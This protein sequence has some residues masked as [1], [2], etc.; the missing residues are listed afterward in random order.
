[1]AKTIKFNLRIDGIAIRSLED[2]QENFVIDDLVEFYD[3]GLLQK[4]LSVRGY[5]EQARR[6]QSFKRT[7]DEKLVT[8]L[9][10]IFE[11]PMEKR[12]FEEELLSL[13]YKK[14]RLR[15]I[16]ENSRLMETRTAFI[17]KYH[18]EYERLLLSLKDNKDD[19]PSIKVTL[20]MIVKLYRR[21]FRVDAVRLFYELKEEAPLAIFAMLMNEE[22]RKDLESNVVID[23]E[24][25]KLY[26]EER[27]LAKLGQNLKI[28]KGAT[29]GYWKNLCDSGKKYMVVSM[30]PGNYVGSPGDIKKEYST[31]ETNGFYLILDGLIYKSNSP[32]QQ[33]RYMEV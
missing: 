33:L 14:E 23:K 13:K 18:D 30:V 1:M 24:I 25:P 16:E 32:S 12:K 4:W 3:Q 28:F 22:L 2:L 10:N 5:N 20:D 19:Y 8:E 9:I 17:D 11:I 6:I 27:I 15:I 21:L 31:T 29:D 26:S 7:D